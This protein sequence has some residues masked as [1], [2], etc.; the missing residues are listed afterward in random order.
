MKGQTCLR[1]QRNSEKLFVATSSSAPNEQALTEVNWPDVL[2]S[3]EKAA[4]INQKT[5][6]RPDPL[7]SRMEEK[8]PP[9]GE[10][11]GAGAKIPEWQSILGA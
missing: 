4:S 5:K 9:E 3:S 11:N 6:C 2:A 7:L 8:Y 1:P 10:P